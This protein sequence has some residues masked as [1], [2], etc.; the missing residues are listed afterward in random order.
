MLDYYCYHV[1][2]TQ[3]ENIKNQQHLLA[4]VCSIWNKE[5]IN[6]NTF[7]FENNIF[8]TSL[9]LTTEEVEDL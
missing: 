4:S 8:S 9:A 2:N 5:H 1:S 6:Q 7:L 3:E